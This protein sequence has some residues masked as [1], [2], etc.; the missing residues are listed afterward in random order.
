MHMS[1]KKLENSVNYNT[2][3]VEHDVR[4]QQIDKLFM[5]IILTFNGLLCNN[6]DGWLKK[7]Q[8]F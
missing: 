4:I 7:L 2:V 1:S 6:S 3:R 8:A 5:G